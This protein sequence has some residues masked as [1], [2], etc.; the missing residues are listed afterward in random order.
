MAGAGGR[1]GPYHEAGEGFDE[2]LLGPATQSEVSGLGQ[3]SPVVLF[4]LLSLRNE[5][6]RVVEGVS[7]RSKGASWSLA[8]ILYY[9]LSQIEP[10]GKEYLVIWSKESKAD[11]S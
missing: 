3:N 11:M 8:W 10:T 6:G 1:R 4:L 9:K 5:S 7:H 2:S